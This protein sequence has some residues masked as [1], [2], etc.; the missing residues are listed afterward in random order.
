VQPLVVV[1]LAALLLLSAPPAVLAATLVRDLRT[2]R[3]PLP[4]GPR[5]ARLALA[6]N[7]ER[8]ATPAQLRL[9]RL[10]RSLFE[11]CR[12]A[13]SVVSAHDDLHAV[14]LLGDALRLAHRI[15]DELRELWSV[16]DAAPELLERA[17]LRVDAGRGALERLC[18]AVAIRAADPVDEVLGHLV[19]GV[20]MEHAARVEVAVALRHRGALLS[21]S[22]VRD[23]AERAAPA[24]G[25]MLH[26]GAGAPR[27]EPWQGTSSTATI[28]ASSARSAG[29]PGRSGRTGPER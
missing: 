27:G 9:A 18:E 29:S 1:A 16:A 17:T 24:G 19:H 22:P 6:L 26:P 13:Q 12:A 3:R 11:S 7:G 21:S 15:D 8:A 20:E 4:A 25:H 28:T 2:A 14:W 10:R 5:L 23:L